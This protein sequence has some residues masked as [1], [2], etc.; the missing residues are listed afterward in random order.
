VRGYVDALKER[1]SQEPFSPYRKPFVLRRVRLLGVVGARLQPV[2]QKEG[3]SLRS[4]SNSITASRQELFPFAQIANTTPN[5]F[6]TGV[7]R[8]LLTPIRFAIEELPPDLLVGA[9]LEVDGKRYGSGSIRRLYES[10]DY[11]LPRG[12]AVQAR[13]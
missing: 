13:C 8:A 1:G 9:F 11:P 3:F 10:S 2:I 12:S 5:H 4:W 6:G 7:S